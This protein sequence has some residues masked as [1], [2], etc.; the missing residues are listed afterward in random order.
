MRF[1]LRFP[2]F[3]TIF[4]RF[5][6]NYETVDGKKVVTLKEGNFEEDKT[7]FVENDFPYYFVDGISHYLIWSHKP[8]PNE[9]VHTLV[10]EKVPELF[11][12]EYLFFTNPPHLQSVKSIRHVHILL[13]D[14]PQS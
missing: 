12:K 4:C 5:G 2:H 10:R 14:K 3:V 11:N 13:R 9:Q 6:Y 7:V 8:V 1:N